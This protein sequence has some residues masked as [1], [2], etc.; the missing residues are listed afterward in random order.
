MAVSLQ[1]FAPFDKQAFRDLVAGLVDPGTIG[2]WW[3]GDPQKFPG[4]Q[5]GKPGE[6]LEM[7]VLGVRDLGYEDVKT[8]YDPVADA[9]SITYTKHVVYII[10]FTIK[11]FSFEVPAYNRLVALL[12]K[13]RRATTS[14]LMETFNPPLAYALHHPITIPDEVADNRPI[15][16]ASVNVEFNSLV[17]ESDDSDTGGYITS[18]NDGPPTGPGAPGTPIAHF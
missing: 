8:V 14:D 11:S 1:I 6:Y 10:N 4:P 7:D 9:N 3:A 18:I 16:A 17:T 12:L 13:F 5:R 2:V 15:Y